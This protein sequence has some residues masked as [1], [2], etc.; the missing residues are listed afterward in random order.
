MPVDAPT[1]WPSKRGTRAQSQGTWLYTSNLATEGGTAM[2]EK[3]LD[4][5]T[6]DGEM[7]TFICHP[8]RNEPYPA[9]FFL[10]DAHGMREELKDMA[11]RS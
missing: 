4:V 1:K 11:R 10:M 9:V 6:K 2:I 5:T 8:E 3:T 7:E